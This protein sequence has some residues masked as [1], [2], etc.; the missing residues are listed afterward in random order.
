M[1]FRIVGSY[2]S[3]IPE[4]GNVELP[5]VRCCAVPTLDLFE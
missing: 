1:F 2:N 4:D 5:I 3:H